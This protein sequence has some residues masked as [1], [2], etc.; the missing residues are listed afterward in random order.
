V[1][2]K[3]LELNFS[4]MRAVP[5]Q[6]AVAVAFKKNFKSSLPKEKLTFTACSQTEFMVLQEEGHL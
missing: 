3:R 4:E 6:V 1:G 5:W 2:K